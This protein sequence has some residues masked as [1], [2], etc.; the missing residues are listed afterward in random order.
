LWRPIRPLAEHDGTRDEDNKSLSRWPTRWHSTEV[1]LS[2]RDSRRNIITTI[3]S[4][5][6]KKTSPV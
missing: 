1:F 4:V 3:Y 6:Q 2:H 5:R